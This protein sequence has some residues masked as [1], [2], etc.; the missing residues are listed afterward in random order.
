MISFIKSNL[1]IIAPMFLIFLTVDLFLVI[2]KLKNYTEAIVNLLISYDIFKSYCFSFYSHREYKLAIIYLTIENTSTSSTDITKIQL[3]DSSKSY[4]AALPKINDT[5]NEIALINEDDN[6]VETKL[7]TI[8]IL[9]ENILNNTH[10]S[11]KGVLKGYAVFENVEPIVSTKDYKI[12]IETPNKVFEK[13]IT[14]NPLS[15]GF[16][17]INQS[18]E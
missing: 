6:E 18:D 9:S 11:P 1:T 15:D 7:I 10:L 13:E 4:L 2:Y 14:I 5:E 16:Q 8:N 12:I 17:L 3:I